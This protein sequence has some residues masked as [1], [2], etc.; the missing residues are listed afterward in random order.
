MGSQDGP[1]AANPAAIEKTSS[2]GRH[3]AAKGSFTEA[4]AHPRKYHKL[5][6]RIVQELESVHV[7]VTLLVALV[8]ALFTVDICEL[9]S[10]KDSTDTAI[11]SLLLIIFA[12]F[13]IE[14]LLNLVCRE[15]YNRLHMFMDLVGTVSVL[16][17]VTWV[18]DGWLD[19]D[20]GSSMATQAS[21]AA[22]IGS[23]AGRL[24]RL[25]RLVRLLRIFKLFVFFTRW[26][27]QRYGGGAQ[28][29]A[30][31]K[32][33]AA[34]SAMGQNLAEAISHQV[35]I[36][37]MV[38]VIVIPI[39]SYEPTDVT[40][41]VYV[42]MAGQYAP[43]TAQLDSLADEIWRFHDDN[44]GVGAT[45]L[46]MSV[47]QKDAQGDCS[48][49]I[50]EQDWE[51]EGLSS[52]TGRNDDLSE[53]VG[54][55]EDGPAT[56]KVSLE[57]NTKERMHEIAILN[58]V[59]VLFVSFELMF[60]TA[61]LNGIISQKVVRPLERIFNTIKTNAAQIMGALAVAEDDED[62]EDGAEEDEMNMVEAAV[63]KMARIVN[64]VS[65]TGNQGS[66]MLAAQLEDKNMDDSTRDYLLEMHGT[67]GA[68]EGNQSSRRGS[69]ASLTNSK[70]S[71]KDTTS[72]RVSTINEGDSELSAFLSS[73][74][75]DVALLNSW[76]FDIFELSR[77][78]QV[79]Y[80]VLMFEELGLF[81]AKLVAFENLRAFL[82]EVANLYRDN[83]YHNFEHCMDV[84]QT[85][86]RM[87]R[88]TT[89]RTLLTPIETFSLMVA[90]ISHDMDHPGLTNAY[91]VS[92]RD[93]L[94][95]TYN[96][97]SVLENRHIACLYHLVSDPE[98]A[99]A[100]IFASLDEAQFK[101]VRRIIINAVLH[102]DMVHHFKTVSQV[103]V[104][105]ELHQKDIELNTEVCIYE[106]QEDRQFVMAL[107]L[108][109][110]D[111]SNPAKPFV[112]YEK[113]ANC[114]LT[115]F[116]EQGDKER[117]NNM[118]ISAQMDRTTTSKP[119]SQIGFM[120]F[121]VAPLYHGVCKLFP[122]LNQLMVHLVDN[123]RRWNELY[124]K[125]VDK[126]GKKGNEKKEE[127]SKMA[128]RLNTFM[129]KYTVDVRPDAAAERL[130]VRRASQQRQIASSH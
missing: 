82:D 39:I 120:E 48:I 84:T 73:L 124:D 117:S 45:P 64:H 62:M 88:L 3:A 127:K 104:F 38:T 119:N 92:T 129:E 41:A 80:V 115:E 32:D 14:F 2:S 16:F 87:I 70:G 66:K 125:D 90:A 111:I 61:V 26:V 10:A 8:I 43:D 12:M 54:T 47:C 58:I 53:V 85:L 71:G 22:R 1:A 56:Y 122:E 46:V 36:L 55:Y 91:L 13:A 34:P 28:A 114:V 18:T 31:S 100:N 74:N 78:Q 52:R 67:K 57:V 95:T 112:V 37:V 77:P 42:D 49:L 98:K 29:A 106:T 126:S 123:R 99:E 83:P 79:G 103:D 33:S 72:P 102:T 118:P 11:N 75:L 97:S 30:N 6:K 107:L 4:G 15:H 9:S 44:G 20:G 35:A 94:A 93:A 110:A 128:A 121:V 59:L 21:K 130:I 105:Y 19:S 60:T 109:T 7:Q 51:A 17:D 24:T 86:Y 27:T 65:G 113:W 50:Y 116:F 81:S 68:G 40:S 101:D 5:R 25:V 69:N 96:D 108:H 89:A 63:N 23:R 76:D